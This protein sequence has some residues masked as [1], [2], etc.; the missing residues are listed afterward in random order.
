MSNLSDF[1]AIHPVFNTEEMR[2]AC[3]QNKAPQTALAALHRAEKK[4]K[5]RR[6]KRGLYQSRP[7]GMKDFPAPSPSLVASRLAP[8]AV[9]SHQSAF[10]TLGFAHTT[11]SKLATYWTNSPRH[12]VKIKGVSYQPI[13]HPEPLRRVGK[14]EWG[15]E[16]IKLA[17]L[18]VRVTHRERTFVDALQAPHWMGGWEEFCQCVNKISHFNFEK[19]LEY[20]SLINSPALYSRLGFFLQVNQKRFYVKKEILEALQKKKS[21]TRIHLVSGDRQ[22]GVLDKKWNVLFPEREVIDLRKLT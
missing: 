4:G 6:L 3:F 2:L 15:V 8:D 17:G 1:F 11:F 16:T 21:R 10:E 20:A 5:V 14:Q 13:L 19:M 12:S 22:H 7:I 9:L 18:A